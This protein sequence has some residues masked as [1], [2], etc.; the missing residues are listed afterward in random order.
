MQTRHG[1]TLLSL[2]EFEHWLTQQRVG[3]T[4]LTLQQHHTWSPSYRQFSGA[5]HFELQQGMKYHHVTNNGWADIGQHFTSFP[6]GSIADRPI[7][8]TGAGVH[9]GAKRARH[10]H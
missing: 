8:R 3:R 10:L 4:V 7:A 9:Q 1:F 6:D 5:N 2:Q